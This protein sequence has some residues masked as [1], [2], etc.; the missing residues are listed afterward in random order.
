MKPLPTQKRALLKRS[1]LV[2]AAQIEFANA[3]YELATAK[4]IAQRAGVATGTFYQ[5]FNNKGEIL[6]VIAIQRNEELRDQLEWKAIESVKDRLSVE[7]FFKQ[8]L[9]YIYNFHSV[10]PQLHQVL[11]QRR[12][13]DPEL[14]ELMDQGDQVLHEKIISL[15]QSF[16]LDKPEVVAQNL[17]AMAEGIIHR[18]VFHRSELDSNDVISVGAR[19][20]A[21][22]FM[23]AK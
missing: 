20:L 1:S 10:N 5:Y 9:V 19:M 11:E 16:N 14:S 8:N 2:N 21:Q 3:G 7:D 22:Y 17:F 4:S 23:S 12:E 13:L 18:H 15:V 6:R